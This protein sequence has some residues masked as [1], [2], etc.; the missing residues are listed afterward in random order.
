MPMLV[1]GVAMVWA[2]YHGRWA[3]GGPAHDPSAWWLAVSAQ[4][5]VPASGVWLGVWALRGIGRRRVRPLRWAQRGFALAPLLL[6]GAFAVQVRSGGPWVVGLGGDGAAAGRG[7]AGV[8]SVVLAFAPTLLCALGLI[9]VR[10]P[11]DRRLNEAELFSRADAGLPLYAPAGLGKYVVRRARDELAAFGAP[12]A[13]LG[14]ASVGAGRLAEWFG[15]SPSW[16]SAAS[17][18]AAGL[19]FALTPFVLVRVWRTEPA[20]AGPSR[21]RLQ[22]LA[23][24]VGLG[25]VRIR[26]WHTDGAMVNAMAMGLAPRS[27]FIL[28][29]DGLFERLTRRQTE[30]VL[31]HELGHLKR[32][33]LFWIL[34]AAL[35]SAA[36]ADATT[37]AGGRLIDRAGRVP[38]WLR[39]WVGDDGMLAL[40]VT[41]WLALIGAASRRFERQAD[42]FAVGEA[43]R[44][45]PDHDGRCSESGA[46]AYGQT[47]TA[48]GRVHHASLGKWSWRHGSLAGRIER[49]R[50]LAGQPIGRT[51]ADVS[52]GWVKAM[53]AVALIAGSAWWYWVLV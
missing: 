52:A 27:R 5:M 29:T 45:E 42:A 35:G 9:A 41:V 22:A 43:S 26:I 49:A 16:A 47:L 31:A 46:R 20:P 50:N 12:L 7:L 32:G 2:A 53:S 19:A 4:A 51:S 8:A 40:A 25:R 23:E 28:L 1:L 10:Y 30:L 21:D 39:P 15:A 33:H 24:R 14:V 48:V 38:E 34:V 18:V 6:L 36:V 17:W 3:A 44:D 11:L 13:V 37:W